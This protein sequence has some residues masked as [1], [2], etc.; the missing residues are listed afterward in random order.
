M[1]T[2]VISVRGRGKTFWNEVLDNPDI[3][4]YIG[5]A[6]RFTPF[7]KS[8]WYNPFIKGKDGTTTEI[9][10]KYRQYI[11]SKPKLLKQLLELKGKTL[12]CWCKPDLCHGD[13]LIKLLGE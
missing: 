4:V 3:Y 12:A 10:E 13:V 9:I 6:V 2:K 5:R 8:K 1:T 7:K 11:L